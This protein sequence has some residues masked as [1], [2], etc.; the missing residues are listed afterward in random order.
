MTEE[1]GP[2]DP[3]DWRRRRAADPRSNQEL[4]EIARRAWSDDETDADLE[5]LS[6]MAARATSVELEIALRLS[7]AAEA[8]ERE[9]GAFVLGRFGTPENPIFLDETVPR[10]IE[11]THDED[12]GVVVVATYALGHRSSERTL[13]RLVELS[14]HA[15]TNV[16]VA[17]AHA[18]GFPLGDAVI[19]PLVRLSAD[20]EP[21]VRD[22]ATF[23]LSTQHEDLDT[24][25]LRVALLARL[26]D[27]DATVRGEAL[28]GLALRHDSGAV[29][30]IRRELAG[31]DVS[32]LVF[33]AAARTDD[34]SLIRDLERWVMIRPNPDL[35]D[36]I[37]NLRASS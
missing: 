23:A 34:P 6:V 33:Q 28:V 24:A 4:L 15:D 12:P 20:S 22:W 14:R 1:V 21:E 10:L 36:A 16:R 2:R 19:E 30:A 29:A 32:N 11:L 31:D 13:P 17:V 7:R 27:E 35:L 18:L 25:E 26:E 5:A 3:E 8:A 9:M 37:S